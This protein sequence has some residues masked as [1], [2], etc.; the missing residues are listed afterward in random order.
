MEMPLAC[1][2]SGSQSSGFFFYG[3]M[4]VKNIVYNRPI[5]NAEDL[6]NKKLLEQLHLKW[7]G[8]LN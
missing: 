1:T 4:Y 6:R 2:I 5:H 3:G 8:P 7:S